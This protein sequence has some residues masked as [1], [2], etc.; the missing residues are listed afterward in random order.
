MNLNVF[1][2]SLFDLLEFKNGQQQFRQNQTSHEFSR[3]KLSQLVEVDTKGSHRGKYSRQHSSLRFSRLSFDKRIL[4]TVEVV[5]FDVLLVSTFP[6]F[7]GKV[8]SQQFATYWPR[9]T[10][11][12]K[13]N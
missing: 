10:I 4:V 1:F 3:F 5:V 2:R 7:G 6:D 8:A 12:S 11:P 9:E 13:I